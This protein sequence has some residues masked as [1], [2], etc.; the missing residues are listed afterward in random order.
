MVKLRVGFCYTETLASERRYGRH[1]IQ[2]ARI[3][4]SGTP[5]IAGLVFFG[6]I[7]MPA[8]RRVEQAKLTASDRAVYVLRLDDTLRG[9]TE[10][11]DVGPR[12]WG[13]TRKIGRR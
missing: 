4:S 5:G 10:A 6:T 2:R 8:R 12:P 3:A 11:A 7:E 9:A 13:A 1:V